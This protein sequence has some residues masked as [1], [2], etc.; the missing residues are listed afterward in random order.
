MI[1]SLILAKSLHNDIQDHTLTLQINVFS[2]RFQR[3][4]PFIR[5]G[6]VIRGEIPTLNQLWTRCGQIMPYEKH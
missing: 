1:E 2:G 3:Y 5:C 6:L 4:A